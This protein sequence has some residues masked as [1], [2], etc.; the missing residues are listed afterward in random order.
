MRPFQGYSSLTRRYALGYNNFHSLQTSWNRRFSHGLQFT[1][2][3]TWSRNMQLNGGGYT[4]RDANGNVVL[5]PE[6]KQAFYNISNS[7]RT[8][9]VKANAVWDLPDLRRGGPVTNAIG[10]VIND[11]QLSAVFTGGSGAPYSVGYSYQ[12]GAGNTVLTGSPDY[13]ARILIV[14]APGK[15]CSSD[16]TRQFN[17]AAFQGPGVR[18]NGLESGQNYLRSCPDKTWDL[19]IARNIRVG[20]GRQL[21]LRAEL[22]N[23]FDAVII[24]NRNATMNIA[25]L[26]TPSVAVNLPYDSNGNLLT[27][28][29]ARNL[30]KNAGFG[31]ATNAN[32]SR[33]VQAQIRF[34]F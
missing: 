1:V 7:D 26:Q 3:W 30:P 31:V 11:W 22:Y 23:A 33:S 17:T 5:A 15:G 29:S 4:T 19:A 9:V 18:S 25:T 6:N 27:G 28:A 10:A 20:H 14:G 32:A 34:S 21:Q 12:N 16:Y 24:N 2:N 13:S 8:H